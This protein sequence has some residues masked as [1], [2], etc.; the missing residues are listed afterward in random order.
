MQRRA[1][2]AYFVLFM[3]ISAGAYA[4]I[5]MAEQPQVD[6]PGETYTEGENVSVADRTYTVATVGG[7]S[8]ELTRTETGVQINETLAHNSTVSWQDISWTGQQID[9]RSIA[10]G[11][12]LQYDDTAHQVILNTSADPAQLR[13]EQVSNRS[14]FETI[15]LD[16][17]VTVT[18]DGQPIPDATVTEITDTEATLSLGND[19]LVDIPNETSLSSAEL[20]AQQN[21]TRLLVLDTDVQNSFGTNPDGSEYVQYTNG[22]EV[23]P[24]QYLPD[25]EV[26]VIEVGDTLQYQGNETTVENITSERVLLTRMG[27]RT[28]TVEFSEGSVTEVNGVSYLAHF[29]DDSTLQL[30][31][32]TTENYET[33]QAEQD[34]ISKYNERKAGLWGVIILSTIAGVILLTVAYLPVKD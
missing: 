4:Y 32:N 18:V 28:E 16:G 12:T 14:V 9:S 21:A 26:N 25:P 8:G 10:N 11:S 6:V 29:P 3:V 20:I 30:V 23:P 1:A 5:G 7:S 19:Y 34:S 15:E 22:T 33:Y 2:A 31:E 27:S 13:L 17:T 24:E